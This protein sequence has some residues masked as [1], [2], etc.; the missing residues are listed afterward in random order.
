M[1]KFK[2]LLTVIILCFI[3]LN[4]FSQIEVTYYSPDIISINTPI[5][6]IQDNNIT[7]ELKT[8]SNTEIKDLSFELDLFYQFKNRKYHRFSAGF[9]LKVDPFT[10]GG[11]GTKFLMPLVLEIFP[12]QDV[13]KVS[14]VL[15]LAPEI[16][17]EENY[18]LRSL[19]GFRYT[20]G[21]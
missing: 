9:G 5:V 15:E 17:F 6:K 12:L 4:V 1:I 14:L 3:S 8:F 2:K 21:D 13:K 10:D 11:D 7:S 18:R 20:F 16:S 19:I